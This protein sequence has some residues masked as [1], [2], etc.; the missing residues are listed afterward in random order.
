[1][2]AG[3]PAD[4]GISAQ[5]VPSSTRPLPGVS[6]PPLLSLQRKAVDV[7]STSRAGFD[8]WKPFAEAEL[9]SWSPSLALRA[10]LDDDDD[11][12]GGHFVPIDQGFH[13][14]AP[15]GWTDDEESD[16]D[17]SDKVLTS[18]CH[19]HVFVCW[20]HHSFPPFYIIPGCHTRCSSF[21]Q[22]RT[23]C[24]PKHYTCC[25]TLRTRAYG[26]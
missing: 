9:T 24:K 16:T 20:A 25:P 2:T 21:K 15:T 8:Q 12:K 23:S 3:S 22:A 4:G 26:R 5:A 10:P 19:R 17:V 11:I 13:I 7:V 6:S 18:S 1:M 14:T